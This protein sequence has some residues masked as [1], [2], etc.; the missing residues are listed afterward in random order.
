[1]HQVASFDQ[2][3]AHL[4]GQVGVLEIGRVVDAGGQQHNRR[5][6]APLRSQRPQRAQKQ[7]GVM[8]DRLHAVIAE[9]LGKGPLHHPAAGQHVG[10]AAGY[11][12]IVFQNHEFSA[13]QAKKIRARDGDVD[14]PRHLQTAHLPAKLAAAVH[15][16]ARHMAVVE[17]LAVVINIVQKEIEGGDSLGKPLFD[18]LPLRPG[19]HPRQQVI[20]KDS[21]P[22]LPHARTR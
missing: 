9:E 12:E 5:V 14:I 6:V 11:P 21:S 17:N 15:D 7:L 22:S 13:A 8:F 1:M 3:D 19:D 4:P 2:L 16:L 20:G 10:D 18:V